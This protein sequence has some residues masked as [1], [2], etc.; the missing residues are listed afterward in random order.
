M[1]IL[2]FEAKLN[3]FE[4]IDFYSDAEDELIDIEDSDLDISDASNKKTLMD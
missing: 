1:D 2:S 4:E 3:D